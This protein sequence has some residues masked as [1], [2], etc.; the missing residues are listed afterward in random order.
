MCWGFLFCFFGIAPQI[1]K[2]LWEELLSFWDAF[3]GK[4]QFIQLEP[5]EK[6]HS[7]LNIEYLQTCTFSGS[8]WAPPC[9]IFW[10]SRDWG[11]QIQSQCRSVAPNCSCCLHM[12]SGYVNWEWA[13]VFGVKK[14]QKCYDFFFR[15]LN[16]FRTFKYKN[17]VWLQADNSHSQRLSGKNSK[18]KEILFISLSNTHRGTVPLCL[19]QASRNILFLQYHVLSLS[20]MLAIL[21][22]EY[23]VVVKRNTMSKRSS[24]LGWFFLV[25]LVC[26]VFKVFSFHLVLDSTGTYTVHHNTWTLWRTAWG[27]PAQ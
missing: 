13:S 4:C 15:T 12:P 2:M 11:D 24:C 25:V 22:K 5:D 8:K 6:F 17:K 10:P 26:L 9:A 1:Y 7:A 27:H 19:F 16:F 14:K 23:F 21:G 20:E 3:R 18:I